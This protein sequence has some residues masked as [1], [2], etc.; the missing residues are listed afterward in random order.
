MNDRGVSVLVGF[1]LLMMILMLFLSV[2]Q[3]TEVPKICEKYESKAMSNYIYTFSEL[4]DNLANGKSFELSVKGV[5]YPNYLFLMT[6]SPSS[7]SITT[8][9][10]TIKM[11][12]QAILPNGSTQN[13]TMTIPTKWIILTP[14]FYYYPNDKLIYENTAVFRA[15][16]NSKMIPVAQQKMVLGSTINI[17]GI[18]GRDVSISSTTPQN[19]YLSLVSSGNVVAKNVTISFKSVN[20]SYWE[21]FG[22]NVSGDL[23]KFNVSYAKLNFRIYKLEYPK[24]FIKYKITKG[25][26]LLLENNY[27]KLTE[28]ESVNL[29]IKV[30]DEY[31]MPIEGVDIKVKVNGNIGYVSA[32][33]I[34]TGIDGIAEVTFNAKT[35]GSGEVVFQT[36]YGNVSYKISVSATPSLPSSGPFTVKWLNKNELDSYYGNEWNAS[37]EGVTKFLSV[38]VTYKEIPINGVTVNFVSTNSSVVDLFPTQN[39]TVNGVTGVEAYAKANGSVTL[40]AYTSGSYDTLNLTLVGVP[41]IPNNWWNP[42]WRYRIPINITNYGNSLYNYQIMIVLNSNFNWNHVSKDARDIRFVD[43]NNQL[44]PY[45][46]EYWNY[47]Q[48]A[49]IWVKLNEIKSGTTTIYMYYG[50]PEAKGEGWHINPD[51]GGWYAGNGSSVFLFF[52]DFQSNDLS[53]YYS[54]NINKWSINTS[55][56]VLYSKP[57][58]YD[59]Y[60]YVL[61]IGDTTYNNIVVEAKGRWTKDN[62]D[63]GIVISTQKNL[64]VGWALWNGLG[65]PK[66]QKDYWGWV[67]YSFYHSPRSRFT[68]GNSIPQ[69]EWGLYSVVISNNTIKYMLEKYSTFTSNPNSINYKPTTYAGKKYVGLFFWDDRVHAQYDWVFIRKYSANK[70]TVSLGVEQS[71][72]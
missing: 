67:E 63:L 10:E 60:M 41:S 71:I 39:T 9:N 22:A 31:F 23:V 72:S 1:I 56:G 51:G 58:Y 5:N 49:I 50:N 18:I 2:I 21:N 38:S 14:G 4:S 13:I 47:G 29:G 3:S 57:S 35:P 32:D 25:R 24:S 70:L 27:V 65:S 44:L 19:F 20:P 34:K 68:G 16:R 36:P 43:S 40:I 61:R 7:Y 46:I 52:D 8:K 59:Y 48:K 69:N 11:S 33:E 64:D 37:K 66:Q 17:V 45:W 55:E 28:G 6:P 53:N 62:D 30:V 15:L 54:N 26:V 12:Y 42:T